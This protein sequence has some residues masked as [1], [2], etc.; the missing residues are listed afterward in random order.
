MEERLDGSLAIRLRDKY[1]NFKILPA[2]P[3]K[4]KELIAA[5]PAK[6]IISKPPADHPWRKQIA[7]EIAK[8]NC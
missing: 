3:L 1:L 8:I 5:I 7:A 2:K 4:A 6:R